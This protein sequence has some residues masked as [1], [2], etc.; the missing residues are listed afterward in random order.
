M[1][2]YNTPL[3]ADK[4]AAAAGTLPMTFHYMSTASATPPSK[5]T[6]MAAP[7]ARPVTA[8]ANQLTGLTEADTDGTWYFHYM[9]SNGA[10]DS[11]IV[12][13]S[14]VVTTGLQYVGGKTWTLLG[15][16]SPSSISLTDLVGGLDTRPSEG[17]FVL[18]MF[19]A[20]TIGEPDFDME[21]TTG[22]TELFDLSVLADFADVQG[23]AFYKRMTSVPD[24][25]VTIGQTGGSTR[26][27]AVAI[28]VWRNVDPVTPLDVTPVTATGS[29]T[30]NPNPPAIAPVTAGAKVVVMGFAGQNGATTN[31]FTAPELS[32]FMTASI[33]SSG[34]PII[35][36]G[37]YDWVSGVYDPAA[38]SGGS[39]NTNYSWIAA[40]VAL[41]PA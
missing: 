17:D 40:S 21:V 2:I 3:L 1:A 8:G 41:R 28:Q 13:E 30:S 29:D 33:D 32:N 11:D 6:L 22:Y 31:V 14:Y 39:A 12:T 16:S 37:T 20:V 7:D 36:M 15:Q 19:G 10:G 34:D 9:V 4:S 24:V 38:F 18:V 5:A 35:G 26:G 27:G 25:V 23:S